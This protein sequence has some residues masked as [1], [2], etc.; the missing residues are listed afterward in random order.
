MSNLR[1]NLKENLLKSVKYL[2]IVALGVAGVVTFVRAQR[3]IEVPADVPIKIEADTVNFTFGELQ[4]LEDAGIIGAASDFCDEDNATTTLCNVQ[5]YALDVENDL[6]LTGT[7]LFNND[8]SFA[9]NATTTLSEHTYKPINFALTQV[10]T[11]AAAAT[12]LGTSGTTTAGYWCNTGSPLLIQNWSWRIGTANGLW[13]SNWTI[14][15]TTGSSDTDLARPTT[16]SMVASSPMG[17][18]T[19]G[20]F[21]LQGYA[22]AR[23]TGF[24]S[25][26]AAA[27]GTST[28][29]SYYTD[30][31]NQMFSTTSPFTLLTG[32]CIV[33][34]SDHD[35]A[36]SSAS[37]TSDGGFTTFVGGFYADAF[38]Q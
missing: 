33:V 4:S 35:K 1:K 2:L 32:E 29:G 7:T 28:I 25:G 38:I 23:Y 13:T 18:T 20:L 19:T 26:D 34:F 6:S 27:V 14:G 24:L 5:V 22:D 21:D 11:T 30:R 15:T 31:T 16:S 9:D 17:T 36:T 12:A 3:T 8:V 37:Y 10:A